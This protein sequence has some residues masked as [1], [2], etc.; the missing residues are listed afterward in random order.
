MSDY[1]ITVN[2]TVDTTR[3]WLTERGVPYIPLKYT[4]D[5]QTYSD[6]EGLSSKEFFDKLREGKMSTTSQIN[7]DEAREALEPYLK[8]GKD[9]LHLSFSS[10][11]SGTCNSMKIAAEELQEEYPERKIIVIDTLCACLGEA[12]LLYYVLKQKENGA[13]IEEAAKW[14]EENKLH[15]CHDVTV[16]DLN[17]LQ[18]GGRISKAAAVLGTLVQVKPIIHMDNNGKLQVIAKERG[19]KKSLNKIVDMAVEQSK[20]WENEIIMITHGDCLKDA[21]YV[22]GRVRE[23]MGIENILINNIGTVIGSHTGPGVVAVF[24]MGNER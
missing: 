14:A 16:D 6:M 11:L 3:E 10:G 21:E 17:H 18:R 22:A 13:T 4:I 23:K 15:I 2:S 24:C 5:G 12:L 7:P 8:E 20:G 9:I 19:R 1:I